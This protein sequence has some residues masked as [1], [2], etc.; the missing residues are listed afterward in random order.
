MSFVSP[1]PFNNILRAA[2]PSQVSSARAERLFSD[3]EGLEGRQRQSKVI[4]TL[5]M[6]ETIR[7]FVHMHLSSNILPR[8]GRTYAKA[9]AVKLLVTQIAM[10]VV[11]NE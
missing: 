2:L 3:F 1:R 5:E 11:E 9:A 8:T 10:E 7:V 4:S 6:Q